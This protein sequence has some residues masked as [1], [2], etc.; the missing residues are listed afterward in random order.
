MI[1]LHTF[2]LCK[3]FSIWAKKA[4]DVRLTGWE[5]RIKEEKHH[6]SNPIS[7][8]C[9]IYASFDVSCINNRRTCFEPHPKKLFIPLT[10]NDPDLS[11][12]SS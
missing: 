7:E 1:N 9:F 3:L 4:P 8:T 2:G 12:L 6:H 5:I 11:P 10:E